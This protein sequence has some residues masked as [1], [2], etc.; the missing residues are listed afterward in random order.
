L[1][2]LRSDVNIQRSPPRG[3]GK[4][5]DM[6][7]L[8][9]SDTRCEGAFRGEPGLEQ[10]RFGSERN[11]E[12][13]RRRWPLRWNISRESSTRSSRNW[14][15]MLPAG[16]EPDADQLAEFSGEVRKSEAVALSDPVMPVFDGL[17]G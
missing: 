16:Q 2:V 1:S 12:W 8:T 15:S 14:I 4:P 6:K 11:I 7:A 5:F 10:V 9:V 13:T 3:A 17:I